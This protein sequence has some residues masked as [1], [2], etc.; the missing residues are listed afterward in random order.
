VS[1]RTTESLEKIR[2]HSRRI[3]K[4]A[5][6]SRL[7]LIAV[8]VFI[9]IFLIVWLY[10][11][12][13]SPAT[14][15]VQISTS[16]IGILLVIFIVNRDIDPAFKLTWIIPMI[17]LPV[18]GVPLYFAVHSNLGARRARRR[19]TEEIRE[20][21]HFIRPDRALLAEM[22]ETAPVAA[23]LAVYAENVGYSTAYRSVGATYYESGEA[24][25]QA[26]TDAIE[27]AKNFVFLEF[28]I[29]DEGNLWDGLLEL[30]YRKVQ[31]GVE[32]RLMY[33]GIGSLFK[34]PAR[35]EKTLTK[36][37]IET[38]VFCPV[39]P[40]F[41][42]EQNNRDHRKIVVVD[43]T[44]AFTGGMNIA[45]EYVNVRS[46]FGQWKDAGVS[47]GGKAAR[48]F[49]LLFLQ[50]WNTAG[51]VR[52]QD[53]YGRYLDDPWN[54]ADEPDAAQA[55]NRTE[56]SG[57]DA[58][59]ASSG[60]CIPLADNPMDNEQIIETAYISM[61]ANAKSYVH[62]I[63]PYLILDSK[64]TNAL[65]SAAKRG[66]DVSII[67]PHIPDK[68]AAFAIARSH[69]P[70]L[71]A[72][73]VTLYEYTPGFVHAKTFVSDGGTAIVGTSNLDFRSLYLH[74]ECAAYFRDD[75]IA[76]DVERDFRETVK[77]SHRVTMKDYDDLT[78][79]ERF[80]GNVLRLFGPLM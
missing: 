55:G 47:V 25:Y 71:L 32:V 64:L 1:K 49:T 66:V 43:G 8:L 33:D 4:R 63:T 27:R 14:E 70:E 60:Y 79:W 62:I 18:F 45:D 36:A 44:V 80:S 29:L 30:L 72:A 24:M 38:R 34:I 51:N 56:K 58:G 3:V 6:Y 35:Y 69:Y 75:A 2:F 16:F 78:D 76:R 54:E 9:Q 46:R 41:S 28:F 52:T 39:R 5:V 10:R 21:K 37:G 67:L 23:A 22:R 53:D 40:V 31:E 26:M 73:G 11:S 74:F 65:T 59:E 12:L 57:D 68:K 20:T 7:L 19:V 42:T 17:A 77:A 13:G 61:L 48:A 50:S 15:I